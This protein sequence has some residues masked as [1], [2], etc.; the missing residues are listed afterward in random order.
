MLRLRSRGQARRWF[1]GALAAAS[2]LVLAPSEGRAHFYLDNPPS[3]RTQDIYGSPQKVGPCG[4]EGSAAQTGIVT[5]F[6]TGDKVTV[7]LRE[8]VFH[9]GHYRIA[10]ALNGQNEL[11]APPPVTPDTQSACGTA[12]IQNP[13]VFP[14]IADGV[15]QHTEKFST[16]QTVEITLPPGITCEKCT[17]QILEFMSDHTAPCFY[18]HCANISISDETAGA[19]GAGGEG[20]QSGASGEGGQSGGGTGGAAGGGE[21]GSGGG[22]AGSSGEAGSGASGEAGSGGTNASGA[23]GDASGGAG[24]DTS[25]GAGGDTSGGSGGSESGGSGGSATSGA[26][27]SGASAPGTGGASG[28]GAPIIPNVDPSVSGGCA[29]ATPRAT[30]PGLAVLTG[31]LAAAGLS[32]RRRD[33]HRK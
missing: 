31:L 26:G 2:A 10:L 9:P 22:D 30:P 7:T 5:A 3:W 28:G 11:P 25:G 8:T 17:L 12:P 6:K 13:P 24:G 1:P 23:G 32:R 20:G 4:N 27:G 33:A 16:A 14:V 15:F 19:G 18:Y 21:A 29:A